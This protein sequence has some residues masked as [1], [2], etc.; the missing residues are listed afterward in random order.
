MGMDYYS[1]DVEKQGAIKPFVIAQKS[2]FYFIISGNW[3]MKERK[4]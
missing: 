4:F 2:L 3:T 1:Y